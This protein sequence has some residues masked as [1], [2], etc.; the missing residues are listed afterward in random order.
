MSSYVKFMKDLVTKKRTITFEPVD[1]LHHYS[2]IATRP[3]VKKKEDSGVFTIPFTVGAFNF[4]RSLCDLRASINLMPLVIYKQLGL[5]AP[6]STTMRLLMA[7]RSVKRPVKILCDVLVRIDHFI[8]PV[9]FVI[10]DC[11]VDFEVTIILGRPFLATCRALA[12]ME[13]DELTF[14]L[15]NE[16]F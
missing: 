10:S 2:V 4:V 14:R 15:N 13:S 12:V 16:E 9:D 5:R 6:K 7:N 3:L 11:E 1:N 8:F